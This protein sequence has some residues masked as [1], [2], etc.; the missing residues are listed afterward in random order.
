MLTAAAEMCIAS[1][2][3]LSMGEEAFDYQSAFAEKPGQYLVELSDPTKMDELRKLVDSVADIVNVGVVQHL[4]RLQVI[5][6][7]KVVW[8]L[9]VDDMTKAWR[10]TL[11]W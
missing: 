1:G 8:D 4:P 5:R 3:G 7:G 10:G 11:D 2:F 9:S 6:A